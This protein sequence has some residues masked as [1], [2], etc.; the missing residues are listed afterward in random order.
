MTSDI[1]E[2]IEALDYDELLALN[3]LI[4]ERL[5]FLDRQEAH[6]AMMQFHPGARVMFDSQHGPQQVTILKFN[7]KTVSVLTDDGRKW[8][9][10][11]QLLSPMKK[12]PQQGKK[13][14]GIKKQFDPSQL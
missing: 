10:A 7:Q 9:V 12:K 4:V 5:K 13:V 2:I 11:P 14:V 8:K 3:E 6:D 1:A